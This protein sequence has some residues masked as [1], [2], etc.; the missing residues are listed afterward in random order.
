[1][2]RIRLPRSAPTH[3]VVTGLGWLILGVYFIV[4]GTV[5]WA[6]EPRELYL[7]AWPAI[8]L[9]SLLAGFGLIASK[10]F[11]RGIVV[12]LAGLGLLGGI[13]GL[14]VLAEPIFQNGV[15]VPGSVLVTLCLFFAWSIV[16][17]GWLWPAR[18]AARPA[19]G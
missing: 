12:F 18:P 5:E 11:T 19:A 2:H 10:A 13:V 15:W 3:L 17:V 7:L 9:T 6:H 14:R 1:M 8:G 16:L 4:T